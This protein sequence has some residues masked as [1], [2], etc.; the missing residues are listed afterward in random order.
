MFEWVTDAK[1]TV[2]LLNM[3]ALEMNRYFSLWRT[4]MA[5]AALLLVPVLA[6]AQSPYE[7]IYLGAYEGTRDDGEFALIVDG[8]G[9][10]TLAAYDSVDDV[11]YIER[12]IHVRFD[13]TFQFITQ[14]GAHVDGQVTDR[15]VS[16]SYYA[17][18]NYA[19]DTRG[20]FV[21]QRSPDDGPFQEAAGYYS[22]LVSYS[23]FEFGASDPRLVAIIGADGR[24]FFLHT[25]AITEP[26]G[27]LAGG[28]DFDLDLDLDFDLDLDLDLDFGPGF[29]LGF[30][31]S[32]NRDP[33]GCGPFGFGMDYSFSISILGFI[34][35]DFD[36]NLP[37]CSSPGQ[38]NFFGG[39]WNGFMSHLIDSGGIVQI[40]PDGTIDGV[41]LDGLIL[42]GQLDPE[43]GSAEGSLSGHEGLDPPTGYWEIERHNS[44]GSF[45]AE[46][47]Y[48]RLPDFDGDGN[49]DI[50]WHHTVTGDNATWIMVGAAI[51]AELPVEIPHEIQEDPQWALVLVTELSDDGQSDFAWRHSVTG[52][53]FVLLSDHEF[54]VYFELDPAWQIVGSGDFDTDARSDI[55]VRD[56]V[57]GENAVIEGLLA[58][59]A[60]APLPV[61]ED[62]SWSFGTTADF[63]GDTRSDVL[64]VNQDTS[65]LLIWLMN[66]KTLVQKRYLTAEQSG[67]NEL[68]GIGDFDAD[69]SLD[70]LWRDYS[71]GNINVT[72]KPGEDGAED[73]QLG[74]GVNRAWQLAAVGDLDGDGA[75]DLVWRHSATGENAAWRI[76]DAQV[77]DTASLTQV[78]DLQWTIRP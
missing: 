39:A 22:G 15:G 51:E 68:A 33:A 42:Q 1:R 14:R 6:F 73:V 24:A 19:A 67:H 44:P 77:T 57:T 65:D 29:G 18:G 45:Y 30:G 11:G 27:L 35:L 40:D 66:G 17:A 37:T 38:G 78:S 47:H 20:N 8:Q 49:A 25:S 75:D 74:E 72:L 13:G 34:D 3:E 23:G 55:F 43:T 60:L 2:K 31:T 26:V 12:N 21:G 4:G 70:I 9:Y 64:W 63:D 71:N 69:G 41:L 52:E 28:F 54:P 7:G 48:K 32:F 53:L 16:G 61:M 36:Y 5:W 76:S 56:R 58:H 62:P 10:G 59:T 50:L 46:Q